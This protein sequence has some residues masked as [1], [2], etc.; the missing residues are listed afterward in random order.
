MFQV[1]VEEEI[2]TH[3]L[4]SATFSRKSYCLWDNVEKYRS[5]KQATDDNIKGACAFHA[6]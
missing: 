1:K 4:Y 6:G 3:I 5:A 2:K